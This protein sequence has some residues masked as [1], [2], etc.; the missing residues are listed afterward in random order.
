MMVGGWVE[1]GPQV[2]GRWR[3]VPAW[4][5][6]YRRSLSRLHMVLCRFMGSCGINSDVF[7]E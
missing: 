6:L 7:N 5:R 4:D 2:H 1:M 3:R